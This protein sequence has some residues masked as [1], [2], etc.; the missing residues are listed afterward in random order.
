[1]ME[2]SWTTIQIAIVLLALTVFVSLKLRTIGSRGE[3][4]PPG[5]KTTPI[6]GNV[7][8]FPTSFPHIK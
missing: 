8:G 5:P 6:L 7:L 3:D 1:M 4:F 2:T